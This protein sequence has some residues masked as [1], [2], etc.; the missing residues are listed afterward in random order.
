M[1]LTIPSPIGFICIHG[2]VNTIT[3]LNFSSQKTS[4]SP[5]PHACLRQCARELREYFEGRRK[6]FSVP[7]EQNGTAFQIQTWQA[8]QKISFGKTRSYADIARAIRNP[9][10]V[11]AVGSANGKNCIPILVPCHRV[12]TSAGTLGGYSSSVW[13]KKWLLE[14]E[15]RYC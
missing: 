8:L 12:I 11:R 1:H 15:R 2:N 14:H 13:R 6:T 5:A 3:A 4:D 7:L 9:K 10:A